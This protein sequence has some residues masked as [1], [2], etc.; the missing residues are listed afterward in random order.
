LRLSPL[1]SHRNTA[2]IASS[3]GHYQRGQYEAAAAAARNSVQAAPGFSV[4]H[5]M[6]AA[7]LA[8]LGRLEDARAAAARILELQ[9]T[10]R[11]SRQLTGVG[12]PPAL[13]ASLS[14][15]YRAAGLP[16]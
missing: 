11:S 1:D 10:F 12:C 16:D 14:E 3:L 7:A 9:P 2:F 4:C 8:K 15:A 13:S 5:L 6:L